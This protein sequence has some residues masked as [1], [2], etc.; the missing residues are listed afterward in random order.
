MALCDFVF[1]AE[2]S[3]LWIL[4]KISDKFQKLESFEESV[5]FSFSK[6]FSVS[7]SQNDINRQR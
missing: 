2:M 1:R 5:G 3:F 6:L 4:E 7:D